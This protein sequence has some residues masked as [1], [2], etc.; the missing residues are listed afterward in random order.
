MGPPAGPLGQG[1]LQG[2]HRLGAAHQ[3]ALHL[4]R[5]GLR[6]QALPGLAGGDE[7]L[8]WQEA[9]GAGQVRQGESGAHQEGEWRQDPRGGYHPHH[10]GP[11]LT[12]GGVYVRNIENV[13][14][15]SS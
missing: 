7:T 3:E 15:T 2:A 5:A 9:R 11:A 12:L 10:R 14:P 4:P 6:T 1:P 13:F 8:H